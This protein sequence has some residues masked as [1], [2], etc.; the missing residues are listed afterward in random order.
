MSQMPNMSFVQ[1]KYHE[2]HWLFYHHPGNNSWPSLQLGGLCWDVPRLHLKCVHA[3]V[4]SYEPYRWCLGTNIPHPA[5]GG[6]SWGYSAHTQNIPSWEVLLPLP[7]SLWPPCHN[8]HKCF[9]PNPI[10]P[11]HSTA[12][13][14]NL[15]VN[16][17]LREIR[18][19]QTVPSRG[20]KDY[21]GLE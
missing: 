2:P 11:S 5:H 4:L 14:S 6:A 13:G 17:N 19:Q 15:G 1:S 20:T 3:F 16:G 18:A 21:G 8:T 9:H 7:E 12:T 10:S